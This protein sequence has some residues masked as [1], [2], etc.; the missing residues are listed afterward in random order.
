MPSFVNKLKGMGCEKVQMIDTT[1]GKFMT[2]K[3]AAM[4]SLRHSAIL[5]GRK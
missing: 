1:D 2:K 5:Y 3:E 4:Y